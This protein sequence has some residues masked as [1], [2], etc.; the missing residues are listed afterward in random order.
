MRLTFQKRRDV[1]QLG[2][3]ILPVATVFSQQGEVFQILPA[4][5]SGIEFG[6]LPEHN[7]PSLRFFLRVLHPGDGLTAR[8]E[9]AEKHESI[10]LGHCV[11]CVLT[12]VPMQVRLLQRG[13]PECLKGPHEVFCFGS[14]C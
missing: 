7:T 14:K 8:Q 2:H 13:M 11:A 9:R 12:L 4:S 6:E 1:F 10:A 5:V 3:I